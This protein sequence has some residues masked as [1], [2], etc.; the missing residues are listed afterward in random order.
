M[1]RFMLDHIALQGAAGTILDDIW[2][3]EVGAR[4]TVWAWLRTHCELRFY[5]HA[6]TRVRCCDEALSVNELAQL[7]LAKVS[8][9]VAVGSDKLQAWALGA[10][11]HYARLTP[12]Q[13]RALFAIG[14]FGAAGVL[15]KE[16]VVLLQV[17]A[18]HLFYTLMTLERLDLVSRRDVKIHNPKAKPPVTRTVMIILTRFRP[19]KPAM[20]AK[21]Y[22][23]SGIVAHVH[24]ILLA[25]PSGAVASTKLRF[26]L[27]IAGKDRRKLWDKVRKA[28]LAAGNLSQEAAAVPQKSGVCSCMQIRVNQQG[29]QPL[30]VLQPQL[31]RM[32]LQQAFTA[33]AR[34]KFDGVMGFEVRQALQIDSKHDL[35]NLRLLEKLHSVMKKRVLEGTTA[36]Q[37]KWE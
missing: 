30:S 26:E 10:G 20:L 28:L 17:P 35:R 32:P 29:W 6:E 9:M 3:T 13:R 37:L 15:Q 31:D 19:S 22:A 24:E 27:G 7:D 8:C 25:A 12:D 4:C 23:L 34:A 18:N 36:C 14:R 5:Q 11:E 21:P 16:L 2:P 1:A 33:V